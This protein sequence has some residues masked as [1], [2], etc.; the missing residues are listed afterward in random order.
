MALYR[1]ENSPYWWCE[2]ECAGKRIRRATGCTSKREARAVERELR[3]EAK[4][5][6]AIQRIVGNPNVSL[7]ME[8]AAL[9]YWEEK[10][11]KL[12]K[13]ENVHRDLMRLVGFFG[14][15]KLIIDIDDDD[16]RRLVVARSQDR[17]NR[18]GSKRKITDCPFVTAQTVNHTV[19]RLQALFRHAKDEWRVK[20]PKEPVWKKHKL[21]VKQKPAR[22]FE[23]DEK[24]RFDNAKRDDF[25][26]ILDFS[27]ESGK[28]F[29]YCV[30]LRWSEV[31]WARGVI[32]KPGKR[33][34]NGEEKIETVAI[35][36]EIRAILE[37]LRGHHSEFV[38][39][40]VAERNRD[41]RKRGR[42]YPIKASNLNTRF[43]RACEKAGING[44]GFHSLRRSAATEFYDANDKD[45]LLT[46]R[47][48][49]HAD[50]K[51]TARYIRRD[52]QNVRA[53]MENRA[54][55]RKQPDSVQGSPTQGPHT[56]DE[57]AA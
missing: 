48:L 30:G 36:P 14:V 21:N 27:Y 13:A 34:P 25:A 55:Q 5:D 46:Q 33:K 7:R 19:V 10:K 3:E 44:F 18:K 16:V 20:F 6:A 49:V 47:F 39:T 2:F 54:K 51:T 23:D 38:F 35:T 15:S 17:V 29:D 24:F 12:A 1:R 11:D 37:P 28:R 4:K 22:V 40:Y 8:D 56:E 53:G 43:R 9:R 41:G 57:Q 32:E 42:R 50:A 52:D 31:H 45:L 26:P